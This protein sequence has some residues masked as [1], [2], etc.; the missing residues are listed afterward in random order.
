MRNISRITIISLISANFLTI[1]LLYDKNV[2]YR[3][4]EELAEFACINHYFVIKDLKEG[5][6]DFTIKNSGKN[7]ETIR[8]LKKEQGFSG[9][10][11]KDFDY[12]VEGIT[13]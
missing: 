1:K 10:R 9:K 4:L 7:L 3:K 11:W 8:A 5:K 12:F 2:K 6:V 13:D